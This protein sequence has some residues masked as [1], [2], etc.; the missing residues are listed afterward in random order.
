MDVEPVESVLV[1]KVDTPTPVIETTPE[2][3]PLV[4]LAPTETAPGTSASFEA[5]LAAIRAAWAKP[6]APAPSSSPTAANVTPR[7]ASHDEVDVIK[8]APS[9]GREAKAPDRRSVQD[10]WG[11]YDPDQGG[12]SARVDKL[13]EVTDSKE[14]PNRTIVTTR[15]ISIR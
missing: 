1:E 13:D 11:V 9:D 3:Q 2:P 5:A 10:Q 14:T 7:S 12:Y 6:E 15:T 8:R 4:S